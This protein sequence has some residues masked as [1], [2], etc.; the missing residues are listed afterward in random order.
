M[1]RAFL[2]GGFYENKIFTDTVLV[3]TLLVSAS[4]TFNGN[5]TTNT[6]TSVSETNSSSESIST[7]EKKLEQIKVVAPAGATAISIVKPMKD[8]VEFDG[9][10]VNYE[11]VPTTDLIMARLTSKEANFAIILLTL[12]P[13]YTV[14]KMPLQTVICVNGENIYSHPLRY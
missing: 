11:I 14:R 1:D 2:I 7:T 10:K 12:L 5:V 9:T 8:L 13:S 3:L 6:G 4:C